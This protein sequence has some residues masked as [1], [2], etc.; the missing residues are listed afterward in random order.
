MK[1]LRMY[2]GLLFLLTSQFSSMYAAKVNQSFLD[3]KNKLERNLAAYKNKI[4]K[5]ECK[6]QQD[7]C[8]VIT[9]YCEKKPICFYMPKTYNESLDHNKK[10]YVLPRTDWSTDSLN[11]FMKVSQDQLQ[12]VDAHCT[13]QKVPGLHYS[14]GVLFEVDGTKYEVE[15]N[16][17]QEYKTVS[18]T[19]TPK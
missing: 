2:V 15:K 11:N 7:G 8:Y 10:R 16:I 19:I 3:S 17:D 12:A 18:F 13:L 5:A 1:K 9:F 4:E 6:Q 14:L